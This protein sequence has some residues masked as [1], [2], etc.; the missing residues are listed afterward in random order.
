MDNGQMDFN[1]FEQKPKRSRTTK[2]R[3]TTRK[4]KGA[5]IH[6]DEKTTSLLVQMCEF[7]NT[8]M[9]QFTSECIVKHA[10]DVCKEICL[11]KS[12]DELFEILWNEMT[13]SEVS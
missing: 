8:C 11:K 6:L 10:K 9:A 12:K 13:G 3:N 4:A 7:T 1:D 5:S 2:F